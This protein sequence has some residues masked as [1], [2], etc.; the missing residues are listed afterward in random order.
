MPRLILDCDDPTYAALLT[1][2][3]HHPGVTVVTEAA[4]A[5]AEP[6]RQD[7]AATV[8]TPEPERVNDPMPGRPQRP[9]VR[10]RP[11]RERPTPPAE[12]APRSSGPSPAPTA[13]PEETP[14]P[15]KPPAAAAPRSSRPSPAPTAKPEKKPQ[16]AEPPAERPD[17]LV[18]PNAIYEMELSGAIEKRRL[19]LATDG[20]SS[21]NPG[22]IGMGLVVL[23]GDQPQLALGWAGGEGTN[24]AAELSAVVSALNLATFRRARQITIQ[25]DSEYVVKGVEKWAAIHAREPLRDNMPNRDLWT[26]LLNLRATLMRYGATVTLTHVPGH[27]GYLPNEVADRIAVKAR[28]KQMYLKEDGLSA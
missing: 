27:Q 17:W 25:T 20:S 1:L 19:V 2:L 26:A 11:A 22:P 9:A 21:G 5:S 28:K 8:I 14:Q 6:P 3:S 23:K 12:A 16:P 15:A 18:T 7:V 24:H 10:V 4:P 13:R